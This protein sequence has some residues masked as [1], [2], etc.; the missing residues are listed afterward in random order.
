M[1][2]VN[3]II[4]AVQAED[5]HPLYLGLLEGPALQLTQE[6]LWLAASAESVI[7]VMSSAFC[8]VRPSAMR[9]PPH[10]QGSRIAPIFAA[11]M[12]MNDGAAHCP[13]KQGFQA[14]LN[15]LDLRIQRQAHAELVQSYSQELLEQTGARGLCGIDRY[16]FEMPARMLAAL[17]GFDKEEQIILSSHIHAVCSALSPHATSSEVEI[18]EL[19]LDHML[20]ILEHALATRWSKSSS[21]NNA[22][23]LAKM[24][25]QFLA[26]H[27]ASV[28][29]NLLALFTQTYDAT[30]G[31]ITNTLFYL[32]QHEALRHTLKR[33]LNTA[34][35][36]DAMIHSILKE[37]TRIDAPIQNT[38]RFV[39]EDCEILGQSLKAGDQILLVLAAANLDEKV[40]SSPSEFSLNLYEESFTFGVGVHACPGKALAFEF[41]ALCLHN[42]LSL[43]LDYSS[44][45]ANSYLHPS[46]NAR[47]R[48]FSSQ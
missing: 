32:A 36:F 43:D 16:S 12:R 37:I 23:S 27:R 10:L 40:F 24:P 11:W 19:A 17:M 4:E 42:L 31:L 15:A 5:P 33:N 18:A 28:V 13:L 41:A 8:L 7:A 44:L 46:V 48:R 1:I 9:V 45:L 30:A 22:F 35:Q 14:S 29:A 2:S 38:R 3:R 39:A 21:T 26:E 34:K 20:P 47:I 25:A 6:G